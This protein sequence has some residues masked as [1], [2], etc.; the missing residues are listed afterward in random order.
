M[1]VRVAI[2]AAAVVFV[3]AAVAR[4]IFEVP[5]VVREGDVADIVPPRRTIVVGEDADI[6][7][8]YVS[9]PFCFFIADLDP[10]RIMAGI[11]EEGFFQEREGFGVARVKMCVLQ[12]YTQLA[13][14]SDLIRAE[15]G[16]VG[17]V[18]HLGP[19]YPR[20]SF[21]LFR[22]CRFRQCVRY[23]PSGLYCIDFHGSPPLL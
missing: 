18:F 19:K 17:Q 1:A 7:E 8:G 5:A 6:H 20:D 3:R 22:G 23:S 11:Y 14:S 9:N 10:P 4:E 15:V 16:A 21:E 12:S 13:H 2:G